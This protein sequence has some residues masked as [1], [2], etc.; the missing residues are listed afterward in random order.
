[1]EE[2]LLP[3]IEKYTSALLERSKT[4]R[5]LM[6]LKKV[7]SDYESYHKDPLNIKIHIICVPLIIL[8]VIGILN[9]IPVAWGPVRIGHIICFL[10]FSYYIFYARP[11]LLPCFAMFAS[12]IAVDF[13]LA[14]LSS[15]LYL[16]INISL[17][18]VCWILQIWGHKKE[19]NKPAFIDN[20]E[21]AIHSTFMAPIMVIRHIRKFF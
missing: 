3:G 15:Q 16:S 10:Y 13:L 17:F 11:Y 9:A 6:S 20:K 5:E 21:T 19:G 18:V 7:I 1:M 14:K 4:K 2:T 12:L 8:S